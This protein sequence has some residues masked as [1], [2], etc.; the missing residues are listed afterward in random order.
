VAII[1]ALLLIGVTAL[2]MPRDA[3]PPRAETAV[4]RGKVYAAATGTPLRG[5]SVSLIPAP[6]SG[7]VL[8]VGVVSFDAIRKDTRSAATDSAGN[9]EFDAVAPG[10]YRLV[11]SPGIHAA[12]YLP[13]GYGTARPNDAGRVLQIDKGQEIRGADIALLTASAIEG[14]VVDEAGEP[15]ARVIVSAA[16]VRLG[17][18]VTQRVTGNGIGAH[19]DDLGRYRVYGL[20]PG[21]YVVMAE[22]G[23]R[24]TTGPAREGEAVGFGVMFHPA[25][26]SETTAQKVRVAAGQDVLGVDIQLAR[27]RRYSVTGQLLNSQGEPVSFSSAALIKPSLGGHTSVQVTVDAAGRFAVRDVEA[28]DYV[29]QVRATR[30]LSGDRIQEYADIPLNVAGDVADA[31]F[32]TQPGVAITGRVVFADGV[33]PAALPSLSVRVMEAPQHTPAPRFETTAPVDANLR[34]TLPNLYGAKLFQLTTLPPGWS[35]RA[36]QLG[37]MDITDVPTVLRPEHDGHLQIVVSTRGGVV[38]GGVTV[39]A[40]EQPTDATIYMFPEDRSGW[41]RASPRVHVVDVPAGG[42]FTLRGLA[43]GRYRAVAIVRDGFQPPPGAGEEFFEVLNEAAT[44]FVIGDDEK[45]T[46]D[47]PLWRWPE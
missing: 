29:L 3:P 43:P 39:A 14:R 11:A 6:E 34:F 17:S 27:T 22:P 45:R 8:R 21:T 25:S 30:S 13:A 16:R 33:A 32:M 2:Q 5:A 24:M 38:E 18:R 20:E 10:R 37:A 44:G 15:V 19:T 47:L 28:G 41:R 35:L 36:V 26:P 1:L 7:D 31:T 42:R 23:F 9:F 46:V 4:V 12:R 40:D